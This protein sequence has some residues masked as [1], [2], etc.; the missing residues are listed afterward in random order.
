MTIARQPDIDGATIVAF[1]QGDDEAF[2]R[3][4]R[5]HF[6][7]LHVHCYRMIGSFDEAEDLVQD[8]LLRAWRH[9]H[10]Y[11]GR[12]TLRA[13]LY[14]IATNACIDAM[15]TRDARGPAG[16]ESEET[17]IGASVAA[18]PDYARLAWLQP[19]PDALLDAGDAPDILPEARLVAR[20]SIELAFL[21]AIQLL[22]V[23]QR[24]V[25]ILRDLLGFSAIETAEM[26]EDTPPAINS[27]LQRARATVR[28]RQPSAP[29]PAPTFSE[30][31]FLQIYLDASQRGDID[32]IVDLLKDD[33]RMT[34]LP[35]GK[36]WNGRDEV[37]CELIER[38]HDFGD[39][40]SIAIAANRQPAM[41]VYRRRTGDHDYRAWAIVLLGVLDGKLREIATFASPELFARFDLPLALPA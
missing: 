20:E 13:W 21:A 35:D 14:R 8:T 31:A 34:L 37:V 38:R 29:S 2:A 26:L 41:A 5:R 23:K 39:V 16:D 4:S 24:A 30:A 1:Q 40:R 28:A 18:A 10:S 15:R 3:I 36:T 17:P 9:R 19:Y 22:P 33:V 12:S 27:A 11:E 6:R 32:T 25:L 7:E